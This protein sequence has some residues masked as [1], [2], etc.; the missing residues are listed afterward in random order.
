VAKGVPVGDV[1]G[2]RRLADQLSSMARQVAQS[3]EQVHTR[4]T[5]LEYE[6]PAARRF[7]S[8]AGD[9]RTGAG[10]TRTKL[11][12]LAAYLRREADALEH[13]QTMAMK[14]KPGVKP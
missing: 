13:A 5:G 1:Q 10:Q 12:E 11:D 7:R 2:M 9:H 8:W 4:A 6:G 14:H 3:G